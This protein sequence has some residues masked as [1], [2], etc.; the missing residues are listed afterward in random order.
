MLLLFK[1]SGLQE[2]KQTLSQEIKALGIQI[3]AGKH[4]GKV[5]TQKSAQ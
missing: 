5:N 3:P 2:R 4:K 1:N